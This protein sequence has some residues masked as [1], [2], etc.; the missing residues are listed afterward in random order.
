MVKPLGELLLIDKDRNKFVQWKQNT[1]MPTVAGYKNMREFVLQTDTSLEEILKKKI[2][3]KVTESDLSEEQ[4]AT[5]KAIQQATIEFNMN[6]GIVFEQVMHIITV[7]TKGFLAIS[8]AD[9]PAT[10]SGLSRKNVPYADIL[11]SGSIIDL[12][13]FLTAIA[14]EGSAG[15]ST[16]ITVQII[17]LRNFR[18]TLG[19]RGWGVRSAVGHPCKNRP[20]PARCY[21]ST[22]YERLMELETTILKQLLTT[23]HP[24][25]RLPMF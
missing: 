12:L 9:L 5:N 10:G 25:T 8:T 1:L 20:C 21:K 17:K 23:T 15:K 2:S 7:P 13:N 14:G 19:F 6:E 3:I 18:E 22:S 11:K 16:A 24:L 4:K